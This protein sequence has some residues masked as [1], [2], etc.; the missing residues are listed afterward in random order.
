MSD[1]YLRNGKYNPL[2]EYKKAEGLSWE[3]FARLLNISTKHVIDLSSWQYCDIKLSTAKQ[4]KEVTGLTP[5][6]YLNPNL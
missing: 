2:Y 3:K 5:D 1:I 6:L 4:I